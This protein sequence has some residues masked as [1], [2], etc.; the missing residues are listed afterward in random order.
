MRRRRAALPPA[1]LA[2]P[3]ALPAVERT[4]AQRW[5]RVAQRRALIAARRLAQRNLLA[6]A[7]LVSHKSCTGPDASRVLG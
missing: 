1:R 2:M 7:G 6:I 3:G 5:A 4:C